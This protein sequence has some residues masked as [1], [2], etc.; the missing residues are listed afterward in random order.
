MDFSFRRSSRVESS[1]FSSLACLFIK[2]AFFARYMVGRLHEEEGEI[3]LF[4][5]LVLRLPSVHLTDAAFTLC[6]PVYTR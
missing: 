4:F 2:L 6:G 3:S 5:L 1:R